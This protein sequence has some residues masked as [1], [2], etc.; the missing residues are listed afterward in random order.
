MSNNKVWMSVRSVYLGQIYVCGG[1]WMS[2]RKN[3]N[4]PGTTWKMVR[5]S[6][7]TARSTGPRCVPAHLLTFLFPLSGLMIVSV[8]SV[9]L[10]CLIFCIFWFVLHFWLE[11]FN[12]DLELLTFCWNYLFGLL[13]IFCSSFSINYFVHNQLCLCLQVGCVFSQTMTLTA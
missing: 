11:T 13:E 3:A 4:A 7:E 12:C 10:W 9:H 6:G 2:K 1:Y 5:E 8:R